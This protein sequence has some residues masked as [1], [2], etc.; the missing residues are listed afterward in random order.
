LTWLYF[1]NHIHGMEKELVANLKAVS[2]AFALASRLKASTIW[3]R[4]VGDARFMDR[5]ESGAG[6]TVKTYDN[7][8]LWFSAN[9]PDNAVW[10]ATVARPFPAEAA[11]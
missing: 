11:E 9:W 1:Y 8:L 3:A 4:A 2:S 10:P 7:A 5:V 6:F